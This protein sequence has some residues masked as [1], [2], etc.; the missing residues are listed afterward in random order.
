MATANVK[1]NSIYVAVQ[2]NLYMKYLNIEHYVEFLKL[3]AY[4]AP[5]AFMPYFSFSPRR[6]HGPLGSWP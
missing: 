5:T 1:R 2:W 3:L 4:A 6:L